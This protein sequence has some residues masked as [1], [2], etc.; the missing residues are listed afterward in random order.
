V[1]C[2]NNSNLSSSS[3]ISNPNISSGYRSNING[4]V[5]H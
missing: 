4:T 5:W 3:N 1:N 2:S